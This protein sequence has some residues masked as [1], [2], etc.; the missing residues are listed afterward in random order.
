M[1]RVGAV[2]AVCRLVAREG[3]A[4]G[5]GVRAAAG[6]HQGACVIGVVKT[7]GVFEIIRHFRGAARVVLISRLVRDDSKRSEVHASGVAGCS[8]S[9]PEG[10]GGES[11]RPSSMH[12]T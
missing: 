11:A 4:G 5:K 8:L 7:R 3:G 1:R 12:M 10:V 2:W 9:C 6:A